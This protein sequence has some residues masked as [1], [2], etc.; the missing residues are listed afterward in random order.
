M[1]HHHCHRQRPLA[2][3]ATHPFRSLP[4]PAVRSSQ[5]QR[6]RPYPDHN[7]RRPLLAFQR[8][9]QVV[10]LVWPLPPIVASEIEFKQTIIFVQE[11]TESGTTTSSTASTVTAVFGYHG[12][13]AASSH[14]STTE[15]CNCSAP[16]DAARANPNSSAKT[17]TTTKRCRCQFA[18]FTGKLMT[19]ESS[20]PSR[21]F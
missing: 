13:V 16:K 18:Q 1:H 10:S 8:K 9:H 7:H 6:R 21:I 15:I 12:S 19:I 14:S 3:N 4:P 2:A 17:F 20:K 5:A 11:C